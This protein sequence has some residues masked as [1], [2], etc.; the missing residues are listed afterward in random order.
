MATVTPAMVRAALVATIAA[1]SCEAW[2]ARPVRFDFVGADD[3][4]SAADK[5]FRTDGRKPLE[6]VAGRYD[7][8]LYVRYKGGYSYYDTESI[9]IAADGWVV[10]FG[11]RRGSD[12]PALWFE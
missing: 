7:V 2:Q 12:K 1:E 11:C 10:A 3:G 9:E 5:R 6:L 8:R 4:K